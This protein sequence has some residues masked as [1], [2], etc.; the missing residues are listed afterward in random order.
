MRTNPRGG[1]SH[2]Y[3][4]S[5]Y[6]DDTPTEND[7]RDV[8]RDVVLEVANDDEDEPSNARDCGTGVD[9]SNVLQ[10]CS[11]PNAYPEWCPLNFL[12]SDLW[13]LID[14]PL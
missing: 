8:L 6:C 11:P 12:P 7:L 14:C 10:E 3:A 4:T 1:S 13:H 2:G 5:A 9:A